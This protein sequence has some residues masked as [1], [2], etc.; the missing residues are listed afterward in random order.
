MH[1]LKSRAGNRKVFLTF[2]F[3]EGFF[4]TSIETMAHSTVLDIDPYAG[5]R[6]SVGEQEWVVFDEVAF[7]RMYDDEYTMA[8]EAA[9]F[10][11]IMVTHQNWENGSFYAH[12]QSVEQIVLN[13]NLSSTRFNPTEQARRVIE[14]SEERD[15]RGRHYMGLFDQSDKLVISPY[16]DEMTDDDARQLGYYPEKRIAMV[17]LHTVDGFG[18]KRILQIAVENS[19]LSLFS[20]LLK[21]CGVNVPNNPTSLDILASHLTSD[22]QVGVG[23]SGLLSIVKR[24]DELLAEKKGKRF[25]LGR[26]SDHGDTFSYKDLE[27]R[28]REV[29]CASGPFIANLVNFRMRLNRAFSTGLIE[30]DVLERLS[31]F[32]SNANS[33][34]L[35]HS[36]IRELQVSYDRGKFSETAVKTLLKFERKRVW[37]LFLAKFDKERASDYF[38][39]EEIAYFSGVQF[40]YG[41]EEVDRRIDMA[42]IDSQIVFYFCGGDGDSETESSLEGFDCPKCNAF[43]KKGSGDTCPHCGYTK[44]KH[45][46]LT[47]ILCN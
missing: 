2:L 1:S 40:D 45:A 6:E 38:D 7:Q 23:G 19:E 35:T 12:G 8:M 13:G 4:M 20:Q 24:Y 36:E 41:S 9:T 22:P 14:L 15:V 44:Q 43:I 33:L 29:E 18:N 26:E 39:Q 25:F 3:G 30:G 42:L 11:V 21:E 10:G 17:R 27:E 5:M 28:R 31:Y 16:P 37:L 32:I 46:E 34:H 47:G